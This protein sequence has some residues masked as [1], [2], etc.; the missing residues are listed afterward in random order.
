MATGH[1]LL[2]DQQHE[3]HRQI[4]FLLS[5]CGFRFALARSCDEA[6]NWL[7]SLQDEVNRFDVMLIN[8]VENKT[9][10]FTL[11]EAANC[12]TRGVAVLVVERQWKLEDLLK[13]VSATDNSHLHCCC[14]EDVTDHLQQ[15]LN[16]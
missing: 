10:L 9:D 8:N 15:L 3:S 12:L 7:T 16:Y 2:V 14:P 11:F 5:L 6:K 4:F 1:I 13:E